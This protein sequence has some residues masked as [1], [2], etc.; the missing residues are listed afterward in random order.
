[1]REVANS[2]VLDDVRRALGRSQTLETA[3]LGPFVEPIAVDDAA[4][5]LEKFATEAAALGSKLY[6]VTSAAM[7]GEQLAD[8]CR[9]FSTSHLVFSAAEIFQELQL[10]AFL[11]TKGLTVS[12][13]QVFSKLAKSNLITQL[14][15]APIGVTGIDSA[16][17]ETGTILLTS[18]EDQSLLVSLLPPIHV[19]IFKASQIKQGLPEVIEKLGAEHMSGNSLTR[20]ATFISGPSRTSDVELTLSIGVHGPKELHLIVLEG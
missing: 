10:E 13:A 15:T 6:R 17:A 14:A 1:M 12:H 2:R 16:I 7:A 11:K 8:L 19:A 4:T 5:I 20:S 3:P 9:Q 18:A